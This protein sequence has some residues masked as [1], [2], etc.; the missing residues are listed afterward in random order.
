MFYILANKYTIYDYLSMLFV[1]LK[2]KEMLK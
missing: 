1:N 2:A